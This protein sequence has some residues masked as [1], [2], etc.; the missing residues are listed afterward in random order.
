MYQK[1]VCTKVRRY[2]SVVSESVVICQLT[3]KMAEEIE[4]LIEIL[5]IKEFLTLKVS[6]PWPWIG[7]YGIPSCITHQPLPTYQISS[8]S[9]KLLWTD[10]HLTHIIRS[11]LWSQPN[12]CILIKVHSTVTDVTFV[13][14]F[15]QYLSVF[16][17]STEGNCTNCISYWSVCYA[18]LNS[19]KIVV[20]YNCFGLYILRWN[21]VT[22]VTKMDTHYQ[23]VCISHH[24]SV[25]CVAKIELH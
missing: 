5:K 22:D 2:C 13:H 8:E 19:K 11:T 16:T 24:N 15:K 23:V 6:W 4:I 10:G 3:L 14:I 17:K 20:M 9:E 7:S 25:K 18:L 12:N 1:S 21:I